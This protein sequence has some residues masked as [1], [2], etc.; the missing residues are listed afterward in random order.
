M[1][2]KII[3]R[4][5]SSLLVASLALGICGCANNSSSTAHSTNLTPTSDANNTQT[6]GT[7]I[8]IPDALQRPSFLSVSAKDSNVKADVPTYKVQSNLSNVVNADRYYFEDEQ[9]KLLQK[10][11]FF[12]FGDYGCNEFFEE[13]EQNRYEQKP[14]FV[15][16]DSLMHTYHLYFSYL[17][18]TLEQ[19]HLAN[20]LS[21]LSQSM[22]QKSK[23]Q[24]ESL[25]GTEWETSAKNNLAFFAVGA[26]LQDSSI[27]IPKAVK[28]MAEEELS[29]IYAANETKESLITK[30]FEDYTQYIPRGYYEGDTTL[31]NYFRA[32]MWYGRTPFIQDDET[33]NRCALLITLALRDGELQSWESA[34]TVTSFFA[35]ASDDLGYYEYLPAIEM[36]YGD[37]VATS[38]LAGKTAAWNKYQELISRLEGPKIYSIPV[39]DTADKNVAVKSFRFM[40]QRFSIDATIMQNLVYSSVEANPSG[41]PR[42]LPDTLDIAAVLGSSAAENL[43]EQKGDMDYKGFKENL[44]ELKTAFSKAPDE[45]WNASLY[46]DWLHTL[47]PLLEK[48]PKGYPAYKLSKAWD[49][50]KLETFL[51]SYTEL[52][53]D[54]ILY[55][56][57]VVAEMGGDDDIKYDDRG[58]VDPEVKVYDRFTDLASATMEGLRKYGLLTQSDEK[59]LTRLKKLAEQL[60]KIS[61]KEL[62]NKMLSDN[63]YD[64]IRNYGGNLEH[65]WTEATKGLTGDDN[66]D[67]ADYPA[68]LV[69]D[70]ATDPNGQVL[71]VGTGR[72]QTI[73]VVVPVDG[74]LRIASGSVYSFYQFEWPQSDRLTDS[75]WRKMMGFVSDGSGDYVDTPPIDIPSWADS[76][77]YH[78]EYNY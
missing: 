41:E 13:Y 39:K 66:A 15:T 60:S 36:A 46:S 56:K 58:Y 68:P 61:R 31:E 7:D 72:A 22:L 38:S 49:L 30:T 70:I 51:G 78:Y 50:K 23:E 24:Y 25:K 52:K 47:T 8:D 26:Y 16:V 5:L 42:M 53:H 32:M 59:N 14:N 2:R 74:S 27:K 29:R 37:D 76:Y 63:E 4:L 35:G 69:A 65:F 48:T 75:K 17:L 9:K 3:Q 20:N 55:S 54:T 77:R 73:Y 10:N 62:Q 45:V 33:S 1:K 12:V 44:E 19:K 43:L 21:S 71:E 6:S 18:K 28:D 34:Y 67:S 40:G 64:L 11:R 57:Q